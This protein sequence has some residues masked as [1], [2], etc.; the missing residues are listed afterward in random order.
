MVQHNERLLLYAAILLCGLVGSWV[1]RFL[2]CIMILG[3][4][5]PR[6]FPINFKLNFQA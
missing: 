5:V 4:F 3:S 1:F 6:Y 2:V